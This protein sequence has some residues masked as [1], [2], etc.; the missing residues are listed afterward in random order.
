MGRTHRGR[1]RPIRQQLVHRHVQR[2]D[3]HSEGAPTIQPYLQP[4]KAGPLIEFILKA[5]DATE[6]GRAEE[7]EPSSTQHQNR[8]RRNRTLD[9]TDEYPPM[10]GTFYLYVADVDASYKQALEAGA[11]SI[12]PPTN[13]DY[14]DRGAGVKDVFGNTWYLGTPIAAKPAGLT[15]GSAIRLGFSST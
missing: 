3:L 11:T 4:I 12:Y 7:D 8:R 5:F 14:G 6:T 13:H 15:S 1:Q 9:A 2:R 10:P